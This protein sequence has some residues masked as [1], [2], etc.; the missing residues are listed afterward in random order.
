MIPPSMNVYG[1]PGELYP[2]GSNPNPSLS[3]NTTGGSS[4]FSTTGANLSGNS[5]PPGPPLYGMGP[6]Y[7]Y[8]YGFMGSNY[9]PPPYNGSSV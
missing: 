1:H 2:S 4:S 9:P 6:S 5:Y 7:D 8:A 3:G